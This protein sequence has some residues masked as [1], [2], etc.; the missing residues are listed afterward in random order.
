[1][2]YRRLIRKYNYDLIFIET[3]DD[4]LFL[5][6]IPESE[7]KTI[8]VRIHSTSETEYTYF[9]PGK[10]YK[11][12]RFLQRKIIAPKIK[13]I[14]STSAFHNGFIKKNM[15]YDNLYDICQKNFFVLPNTMPD[16]KNFFC[17]DKNNE[18][19]VKLFSLGRLNREGMCQKGQHDLIMA[20]SLLG[21]S[22]SDIASC[23]IVG[24]GEYYEYLESLIYK[25]GLSECIKLIRKMSHDEI[26]S[27]L[28][29]SD[30]V[31]LP[32]RFEGMS[33]FALEALYTQNLCLFSNTG[34]LS[35]MIV[36][37][38][39]SYPPQDIDALA[40]AIDRAIHLNKSDLYN[41]KMNSYEKAL[42]FSYENVKNKF[43]K[44]FK[45]VV[46]GI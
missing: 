17:K 11:L 43:D 45:M 23:T 16:V 18:E 3:F 1:G 35:D 33:M 37:E 6:L 36:N 8:I 44:I 41:E 38:D 9:F 19:K 13:N 31:V 2:N 20:I 26:I 4:A 34:G 30:I 46:S 14:C 39:Y 25:L 24:D 10:K 22:F 28:S 40:K 21:K 7:Y 29:L 12:N 5:S 42:S 32:S 27:H 15:F